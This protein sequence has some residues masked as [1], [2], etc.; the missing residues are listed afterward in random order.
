M[1][2][3]DLQ[4]AI[5]LHQRGQ[6]VEAE[7]IY[8]SL[9]KTAPDH[10]DA[11]HL[12]GVILLQRRQVFE[13]EWLIAR[14][15]TIKPNDP[16]ALN[17][18]GNALM[19]L[20]RLEEALASYDKAVALKPDY[21]DAFSNRGNVLM[22][23]KRL[24][25]ALASYDKAVA[26]RPDYAEAFN[27]RGIALKELRRLKE[28]LASCDKAVALKPDYAEAF[29]NRGNALK[30]L[31]RLDEALASYI[32]AVALKP[33]YADAFNNRGNALKELRRLKEA[34]AS[35]DKAVVLK[36][37]HADAFNNRGNAL[38]E[39]RRLDEALASYDK[40]V[41]LKPDYAEAFNNRGIALT[42]L[43][44][45]EEALA[46]YDKAV[47]L[48]PDYAEAFNNRG[49]AL[50]ELRRLEE[51]LASYDKAV[52]LKPD[53]AEAFNNRGVALA[54]LR[55]LEEALA[56]YDK[57]VALKPDYAEAFNNRGIALTK[58]K[59]LDKALVSYDRAIAL[60]PDYAEAFKDRGIALMELKRLEEALVSC[61]QAIALKPAYADG[62]V[63]RAL[64]RLLVGQYKEGWAD[65]EWRWESKTW[66]NTRPNVKVPTWQG[67]DLSGRHLLVFTEQG[68]GDIIQFARY[69][70]LLAR[71]QCRVTFLAPANLVRLLG[72]SIHPLEAVSEIKDT[73]GID[74]QTALMSLPHRFNIDLSSIPN[75]VSYLNAE[76]EL[77]ASYKSRIG[78]SG[79]KVGIAWQGNPSGN[80]D[81]GRSIPLERFVPLARIPGVRLISLQKHV[82]LDQLASLAK[83]VGIESLGNEL[84]NGPDAFCDT[85]AVMNSLDLI[86]TSDTS[87]AHLAGALG[88][89]TWV[90]LKYVP[91]WRWMLD[92][93]DSP[94]YPT[95][96]LFR[97]S[98]RDDWIQVFS[99]IERELQSL[100]NETAAKLHSSQKM[101]FTIIPT[102]QVSWGELIDKMT[103]LEIKEQRLGSTEAVEN[104][105]H[106]LA[107]LSGISRNALSQLPD[108]A[109]F[110]RELRLVNEVLWDIENMIREKEASKSFD[111]E[112]VELARSIY[113][114]NDKRAGLKR[115]ISLLLNSTIVEQKQ[116][117][118]YQTQNSLAASHRT[119][120]DV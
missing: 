14:A 85:A 32:K 52:A 39:L 77:E 36:P 74:F 31:R 114:N 110:K 73:S 66:P 83:A 119:S 24:E 6:L 28:A 4:N 5:S 72:P 45:R 46:S 108:L 107:S 40:A 26:L 113:V 27:N 117:T 91:D 33:D 103:I 97:Q 84:D 43:T 58:L 9:L 78:A 101:Q 55:R 34:L 63:N 81:E 112:F 38:K 95:L 42:E 48:K 12:L 47:V 35:Y 69:L 2:E 67:E 92:R 70:P 16:I 75:K 44:R 18:R 120:R 51:A 82:G 21:A 59:R 50:T 80:V 29:Y 89:P 13:G 19:E 20:K 71:Y 118:C 68:L 62:Y 7:E 86:I 57:A 76:P 54:E 87:I 100:V 99:N 105:R 10:F 93:D 104:V 15:L 106:E 102:I 56:S 11:T 3:D 53:Y 79:F 64:I 111:Q 60:K 22:E 49:V 90:A 65:Y 88:R 23:L 61:D 116:Y 96:R 41:A 109:L 30:E 25:E 37:D 98:Q 17:N 1:A 115:Q 94:W 8:R